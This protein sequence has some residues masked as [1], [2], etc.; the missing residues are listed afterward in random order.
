MEVMRMMKKKRRNPID[1]WKPQPKQFQLL[2]LA[3]LDEALYGRS[4]K[5][6]VC[7]EIGYGG[8]AYGGK[9]EGMVGLAL[10]ALD[11]IP[12]VKIGYF[13]R[14]FKELEGSDGPIE[15]AHVYFP[16]IGGKYNKSEHS[17]KFGED[18]DPEWNEGRSASLRFCHC[19]N[20][21]DVKMYQSW[22]FDILLFDEATQFSWYQYSMLKT[23]NRVS[24]YSK[25]PSPFSVACSNPGGV[26]HM[27]YKKQFGIE[28]RLHE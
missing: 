28:D 2:Q 16:E 24:S 14:T 18:E 13:R 6:A 1:V 5:P 20:E 17:W 15:R 3:G 10:I 9:T 7:E 27:W 23:R 19:Q 22:S 26:G 25:I 8:A 4:I 11:Q 21:A 12:G